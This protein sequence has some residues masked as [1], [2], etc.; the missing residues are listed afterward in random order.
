VLQLYQNIRERKCQGRLRAAPGLLRTVTTTLRDICMSKDQ[1]RELRFYVTRVT[2]NARAVT[3][4]LRASSK[5]EII[6]MCKDRL[7]ELRFYVTWMTAS[8]KAVTN[9][10]RAI[11]NWLRELRFYV[12]WITASARAVTNVVRAVTNLLRDI[13]IDRLRELR[14]YVI[15]VTACQGVTNVLRA[16]PLCWKTFASMDCG[17]RT[18][19]NEHAQCWIRSL[20]ATSSRR[21]SLLKQWS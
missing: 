7:K 4:L 14:S 15:W 12:T 10:L 16:V 3:I 21:A 13:F 6:C 19:N 5:D 1:L 20:T 2:A 18:A 11:T 17:L 9:V 8:A